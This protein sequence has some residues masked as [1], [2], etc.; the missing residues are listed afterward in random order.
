[1]GKVPIDD[2]LGRKRGDYGAAI[3]S[4]VWWRPAGPPLCPGRTAMS[5]RDL[6]EVPLHQA[7]DEKRDRDRGDDPGRAARTRLA[8]RQR[9]GRL[10]VL[11]FSGNWLV[12]SKHAF[13]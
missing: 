13:C 7:G 3:R 1:M 4:V 12:V 6:R 5:A 9:I 11:V 2:G 10:R 8:A